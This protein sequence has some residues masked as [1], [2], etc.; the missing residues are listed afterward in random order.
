MEPELHRELCFPDGGT[1]PQLSLQ[2]ARV[3]EVWPEVGD[4]V[5]P[6]TREAFI[7][8]VLGITGLEA[9]YAFGS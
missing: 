2:D 7:R 4:P 8:Q 6:A 3:E 5:F 1:I 9:F